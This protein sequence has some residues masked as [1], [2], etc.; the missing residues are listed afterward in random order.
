MYLVDV[1][2]NSV[3]SFLIGF[4]CACSF[5]VFVGFKEWLVL[6]LDGGENFAWDALIRNKL[7]AAGIDERGDGVAEFV[8]AVVA[9]FWEVS[10]TRHGLERIFVDYHAW[11]AKES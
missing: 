9:E 10:R 4:D 1:S 3:L 11:L 2:L 5:G 6:S 7:R 8:M